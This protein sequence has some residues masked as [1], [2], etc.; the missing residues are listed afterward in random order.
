MRAWVCRALSDDRSGLCFEPDWPGPPAPGPAEVTV[1][2]TACGLNYPDL[3]MLSG[4]YQYV[5]TLPFIPGMEGCGVIA[6]V[7]EEL[8]GELI[9]QRVI[10]GARGGCL[11]E[12]ITVPAS[13]VRPVPEGLHDDEAA[14]FTVGALTAY[15]GLVVRG[16]LQAHER[17]LVL[18]AGGGMGLAAV[19]LAHALGGE[20]IAAASTAAKLAA[21]TAAGAQ[22]S[23]LL[24]RAA[25]DFDSLKGSVDLVFDP[26]G[27]AAV[28]PALRSL[29]WGGRYLVIGFVAGAPVA[30]PF[31]RLLLAGSELVG[32]RAGEFGRQDPVAGAAHLRAIDALGAA[33]RLTPHIGLRLPIFRADDAF[34]AMSAGT[35]TGKAVITSPLTASA[36]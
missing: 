33:G 9:G 18:G 14:A 35:L 23:L 4:G 15:V 28:L 24:D 29:R 12:Q 30:L 10:I 1:A 2:I 31:N 11:A 34:A 22:S 32:V 5:P 3:L 7:G 17:V 6:A 13:S 20:V 8:S 16:R 19:A 25:P 26:I 27:G 36:I 21:A